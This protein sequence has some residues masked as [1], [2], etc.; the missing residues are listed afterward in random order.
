MTRGIH[1]YRNG[2]YSWQCP[3][4]RRE[5]A[6]VLAA[7]RRACGLGETPVDL[8]LADDAFISGLNAARLGCAGPTNILSF[9]PHPGTGREH[10]LLVLSLD[11]L[12][13]ESLLYGQDAAEHL[14]RLLAHG[15]AHLGGL[16]HGAAMDAVQDAAFAAGMR[17][18]AG[19]FREW[20]DEEKR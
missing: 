14:V 9:P 2:A 13:R 4:S 5:L 3:L 15:M 10:A 1:V 16:D 12:E 7:M 17:L 20:R 11:T 18:C 8:T 6:E 19:F